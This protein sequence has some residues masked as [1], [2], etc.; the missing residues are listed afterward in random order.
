MPSERNGD[1]P[2]FVDEVFRRSYA[3]LETRYA[4]ATEM[5][6]ALEVVTARPPALPRMRSDLMGE[7]A[8]WRCPHC[9]GVIEKGD[10]F[11]MHCG[12]QLANQ[13]RRCPRCGGFPA[14]LDRHCMFCGQTLSLAV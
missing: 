5:A 4:S 11:C 7:E 9:R 8:R 3:R 12:A 14:L 2:K 1:V 6:G 13:V 10:Q